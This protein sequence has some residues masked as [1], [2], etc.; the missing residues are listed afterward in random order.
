MLDTGYWI[1]DGIP[2]KAGLNA[3]CEGLEAWDL[4]LVRRSNGS[5]GFSVSL[6]IDV[7]PL[8]LLLFIL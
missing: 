3:Q 2:P 8:Y 4:G 1:L 7:I 6:V 5:R